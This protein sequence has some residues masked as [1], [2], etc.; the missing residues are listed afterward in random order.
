MEPYKTLIKAV[1]ELQN[2]MLQHGTL[3]EPHTQR[4]HNPETPKVLEKTLSFI[5]HGLGFRV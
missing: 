4:L 2:G 1:K 5:A 3:K